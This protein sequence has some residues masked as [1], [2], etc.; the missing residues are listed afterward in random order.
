MAA[1]PEL[2]AALRARGNAAFKSRA[3]LDAVDCYSQ[4]LALAPGDRALLA[5]RSA[6]HLAAGALDEALADAQAV[7]AQHP[8]WAKGWYRLGRALA[9]AELWSDAAAALRRAAALDPASAAAGVAPL[10]AE[11]SARADAAA[12]RAAAAVA[13]TARHV[14]WARR[15][16]REA[17]ARRE[18][19]GQVQRGMAAF[20]WEPEDFEWRPTWLAPPDHG[21]S[22]G[23]DLR[24]AA[25]STSGVSGSGSGPAGKPPASGGRTAAAAAP[26]P[27]GDLRLVAGLTVALADLESPARGAALAG[28]GAALDWYARALATAL[29]ARGGAP[30]AG[31]DAAVLVLGGGGGGL[32]A[33][34]AAAAG[35]RHVTVIERTPLGARA[36]RALLDA[37]AAA[38][39]AAGC[40][41]ELAPAPLERCYGAAAGGGW[42]AAPLPERRGG[43]DGGGQ[44]P[45]GG[46]PLHILRSPPAGLVV[47]DLAADASLLGLG[48]LRALQLAASHGLA[49]PGARLVPERVA[50]MGAPA[51]CCVPGAG[52]FDLEAALRRFKWHPGLAPAD[53]AGE[54]GLRL[55][56]APA[57]LAELP[58][59]RLLSAAAAVA[60]RAPPHQGAAGGCGVPAAAPPPLERAALRALRGS[61]RVEAAGPGG[62]CH[63]AA[64]WIQL[65]AP[66]A[67]ALAPPLPTAR[68]GGGSG[69][70]G[71]GVA[72]SGSLR[73]ALSYLSAPVDFQP[74]AAAVLS[75]APAQEGC[76]LAAAVRPAGAG[77]VA[78][79]APGPRHALLPAWHWPM[80]ADA[81]RNGAYDTAIRSAVAARRGARVL[82]IGAGSGLLSLMAARPRVDL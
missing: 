27:Q 8:A 26:P 59:E 77:A 65:H 69:P 24:C 31:D 21:P 70:A 80:L 5:N 7:T 20:E 48:L 71:G 73:G 3:Y 67:G 29:R 45:D 44:A 46:P 10:L 47:T 23:R 57:R 30:C 66:G 25:A 52:G 18:L 9:A 6:A 14:A 51:E 82:D 43:G 68:D 28:D 37:N 33:L 34:A 17:S 62:R 39:E 49:A 4:A 16:A 75:L 61:A 15:A 55:L 38:L 74:G 60:A 64:L 50:V 72:V 78:A 79:A 32:L 53:L 2:Q 19:L 36:A 13:L 12:R 63:A 54:P 40:A 22:S 11:A 58:L 35:A 1:L 81:A 41:V 56:S 76:S 42:P